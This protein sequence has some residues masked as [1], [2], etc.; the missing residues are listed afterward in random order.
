MGK[1]CIK[2]LITGI[3][4]SIVGTVILAV[5]AIN[6]YIDE[7]SLTFD[8][9]YRSNSAEYAVTTM[10]ETSFVEVV[11]DVSEGTFSDSDYDY[12]SEADVDPDEINN[13]DISIS[14]GSFEIMPGNSFRLMA[15][16]VDAE[17]LVFSVSGDCL[18]V[19]YSPDI[20]LFSFDWLNDSAEIILIV[21]QKVY[22]EISIDMDAGVTNVTGLTAN[23][24]EFDMSAGE[25]FLTDISAYYSSDIKMSAGYSV[26]N[27]CI[28]LN[29]SAIQVSAGNMEFNNCSVIGNSDIKVSAGSLYMDLADSFSLYNISAD[30]SAGE[31]FINGESAA[32]KYNAYSGESEPLGDINVKVSAGSCYINFND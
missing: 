5:E 13:I 31:V 8:D 24:F 27:R 7:D 28:L 2:I 25:A 20:K 26:F 22:E 14:M 1:F 23:N 32:K 3:I 12:V 18:E 11:D 16:G 10:V 21:P 6:G 19:K 15:N 30:R 9:I 29:S 17:Q 4:M